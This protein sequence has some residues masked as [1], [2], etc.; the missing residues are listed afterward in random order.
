MIPG[1]VETRI[2][3]Y[4]FRHYLPEDIQL[5]IA[6]LLLPYYLDM[7]PDY[8]GEPTVDDMVKLATDYLYEALKS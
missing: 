6:S 2:A 1:E 8:E 4:Y 7:V 5:E 3:L